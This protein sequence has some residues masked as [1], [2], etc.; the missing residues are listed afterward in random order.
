M[1]QLDSAGLG[2]SVPTWKAISSYYAALT[3]AT[4]MAS[5][6]CGSTAPT[7]AGKRAVAFSPWNACGSGGSA[8]ETVYQNIYTPDTIRNVTTTTAVG[9]EGGMVARTCRLAGSLTTFAC[10]YVNPTTAQGYTASWQLTPLTGTWSS[11]LAPLSYA[12]YNYGFVSNTEWRH[13]LNVDSGYAITAYASRAI[14]TN[15]RTSLGWN[16][17]TILCDQTLNRGYCPPGG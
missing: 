9:R 12:F 14:G 5:R 4:S 16:R 13:W 11:G 2:A 15:A 6:Y 3:V 7:D 8:C 17:G 1:W 10:Y